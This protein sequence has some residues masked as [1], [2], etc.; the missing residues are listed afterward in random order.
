MLNGEENHRAEKEHR[1]HSFEDFH[2]T[3]RLTLN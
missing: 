1:A 2:V 3:S